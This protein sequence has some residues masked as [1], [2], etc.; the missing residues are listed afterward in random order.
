MHKS[1]EFKIK[2]YLLGGNV[3]TGAPLSGAGGVAA[4]A[5][6]GGSGGAGCVGFGR[7]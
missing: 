1:I 2:N 7:L 3:V 5:L 6:G 4:L